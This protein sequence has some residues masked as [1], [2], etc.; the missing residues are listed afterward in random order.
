MGN[1]VEGTM[2]WAAPGTEFVKLNS[3][4][5]WEVWNLSADAHPFHMHLIDFIVVARHEIDLN[6]T[7]LVEQPLIQHDG[8]VGT[9]YR[10]ENPTKGALVEIG[11]ADG[12]ADTSFPRDVV[13]ALPG[14][15]TTIRAKFDKLGDYPWHCHILAHEDQ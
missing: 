10:V 11:A 7:V 4:E 12:Y 9:G 6:A 13:T 15:I 2:T 14:Q 8:A 5:E 1:E 3:V